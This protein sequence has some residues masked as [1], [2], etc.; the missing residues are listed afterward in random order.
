MKGVGWRR[1]IVAP[2]DDV[3]VTVWSRD[4]A[5]IVASVFETLRHRAKSGVPVVLIA[6][7]TRAPCVEK[8][9]SQSIDSPLYTGVSCRAVTSTVEVVGAERRVGTIAKST[10]VLKKNIVCDRWNNSQ[11]KCINLCCISVNDVFRIR[12]TQS[13]YYSLNDCRQSVL[14]ETIQ[15]VDIAIAF[16]S[17]GYNGILLT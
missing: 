2:M 6:V 8:A 9:M 10:I 7:F 11:L 12:K 15:L 13:A 1:M 5:V 4:S 3:F 17:I 14:W 16:S